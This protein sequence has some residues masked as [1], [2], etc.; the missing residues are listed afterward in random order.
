MLPEAVRAI[1]VL[2]NAHEF[3]KDLFE[4]KAPHYEDW[5]MLFI[6][7]ANELEEKSTVTKNFVKVTGRAYGTVRASL[8]R[9]EERGYIH[10]LQKIVRSELYVPTDKLKKAVKKGHGS[11]GRVLK[12]MSVPINPAEPQFSFH[13]GN[14]QKNVPINFELWHHKICLLT[15]IKNGLSINR[16]MNGWKSSLQSNI[17]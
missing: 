10:T 11:F 2:L 8:N 16:K 12:T 5:I 13:I 4:T 14:C 1:N 17:M 3:G 15:L 6:L 7:I 9:F